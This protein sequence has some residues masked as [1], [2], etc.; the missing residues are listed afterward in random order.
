MRKNT[1]KYG[2][3]IMDLCE[4]KQGRLPAID[5]GARFPEGAP[6]YRGVCQR[7]D[8]GLGEVATMYINGELAGEAVYVVCAECLADFVASTDMFPADICLVKLKPKGGN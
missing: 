8:G 4:D 7:C 6:T 2:L 5:S 3:G 1:R